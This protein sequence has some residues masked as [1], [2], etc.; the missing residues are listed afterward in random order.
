MP[1]KS[2]GYTSTASRL[3]K[4]TSSQIVN[5]DGPGDTSGERPNALHAR[6]ASVFGGAQLN[7]AS[8]RKL[9]VSLRKVQEACIHH[10]GVDSK[11]AAD[12]SHFTERDFNEEFVRSILQVLCVK[13][14]EGVGDK[15]VRFVGQFL[16]HASDCGSLLVTTTSP[17][18]MCL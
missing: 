15:T 1:G 9:A 3:K 10:G 8:H 5:I 18:I 2:Y 14:S 7:V 11:K 12:V 6:I 16:K 4:E 13:K 17:V